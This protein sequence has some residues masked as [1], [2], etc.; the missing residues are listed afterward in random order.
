[1]IKKIGLYGPSIVLLIMLL[2]TFESVYTL[3]GIDMAD[4]GYIGI[5]NIFV[6]FPIMFF[7]Y[8][9]VCAIF[10]KDSIYSIIINFILFMIIVFTSYIKFIELKICMISIVIFI[11][12]FITSKYILNYN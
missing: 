9:I 10:K 2:L 12:S 3:F 4:S 1:M 5:G 7:I 6:I 8:G 11:I